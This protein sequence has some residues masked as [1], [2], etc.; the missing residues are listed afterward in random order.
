MRI[1]RE[2]PGLVESGMTA[3]G[4]NSEKSAIECARQMHQIC[5]REFWIIEKAI[6]RSWFDDLSPRSTD[7][8]ENLC[9]PF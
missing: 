8:G 5:V 2:C 9:C 1:G 6:F 7:S 3:F 4:L